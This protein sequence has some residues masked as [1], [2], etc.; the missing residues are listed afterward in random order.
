[1]S[2]EHNHPGWLAYSKDWADQT[3]PETRIAKAL[4]YHEPTRVCVNHHISDPKHDC[5]GLWLYRCATCARTREQPC[6]TWRALTGKE[7]P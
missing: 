1:M 4:E 3:D 2:D 5:G 6:P 7:T